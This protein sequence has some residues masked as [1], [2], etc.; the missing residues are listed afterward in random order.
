MLVCGFRQVSVARYYC[1]TDWASSFETLVN[2]FITSS[3]TMWIERLFSQMMS[4]LLLMDWSCRQGSGSVEW[5]VE[6][7][8]LNIVLNQI[9][10]F[11]SCE[12][13]TCVAVYCSSEW[14]YCTT[15]V[16]NYPSSWLRYLTS[17]F[18]LFWPVFSQSLDIFIFYS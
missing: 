17:F 16:L 6:P 13:C 4:I 3:L 8:L 7:V 9:Q 2:K 14:A 11:D 5:K 12:C 1:I 18:M 15:L 10:S